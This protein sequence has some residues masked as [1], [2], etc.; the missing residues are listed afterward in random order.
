MNRVERIER[1]EFIIFGADRIDLN[2]QATLIADRF[3]GSVPWHFVSID[4]TSSTWETASG[5]EWRASI[6]VEVDDDDE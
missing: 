2:E 1:I 6:I 4:A 5:R 3:Y